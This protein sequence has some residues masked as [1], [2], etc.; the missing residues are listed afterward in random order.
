MMTAMKLTGLLRS[1]VPAATCAA[2][3]AIVA[4]CGGGE[5]KA[6]SFDSISGDL[7]PEMRTLGERPEDV[8]G[9]L[10]YTF[11]HEDRMLQGDLGRVFYTDHPTRLSPSSGAFFVRDLRGSLAF[12][13]RSANACPC[14]QSPRQSRPSIE[15]SEP[16]TPPPYRG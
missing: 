6:S 3:L 9:H 10:A 4:G 2:A 16:S 8:E 11:N 13:A 1:V 15:R 14:L 12:S 5:S 7:T